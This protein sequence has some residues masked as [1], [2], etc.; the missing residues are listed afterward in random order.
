MTNRPVGASGFTAS[1]LFLYLL[2]IYI[3][4]GVYIALPNSCARACV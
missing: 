3:E 4:L 2:I 1:S